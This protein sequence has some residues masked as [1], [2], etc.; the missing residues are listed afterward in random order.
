MRPEW[1]RAARRFAIAAI[2]AALAPAA[3]AGAQTPAAPLVYEREAVVCQSPHA[4]AAGARLLVAGGNA[5]DAAVAAAFALAVTYPEAG[6]IG[7]GGFLVLHVPGEGGAAPAWTT[8]DFRERAPARAHA[9]MFLD[10]QGRY[11][12]GRH[13]RSHL[14]VAVPGSVA[15]LALAHQRHGKRPWKEV[16]DPAIDLARRGFP[17]SRAL[18]GSLAREAPSF[19]PA[20]S[21]ARAFQKD[22][23]ALQAGEVWAQEELAA[24][25]ER[26]AREGPR[27]FYEGETARLV[28]REM[29]RG[30]GY[31]SAADLA[32]YQAIERPPLVG[33]YRGFTIVCMGPPSSGGVA[34]LECL[35]ILEGYDLAALGDLS[36]AFV[37]RAAEALRRAF[38]DRARHLGDPDFVEVPLAELVSKD[39]AARL[40]AGI[41]PARAS[42]SDPERFEWAP[43]G[44]Q[45]T[46]LSVVDAGG[47][48]VSLTT[49][50]EES[51]GARIVVPGAGFLLNNEMGDFNAGPALTNREGLIG[52]PANL[53]APGKRMLSSMSPAIICEGGEL[54]AVLGSPGGRTI[55]STVLGVVLRLIDF[56]RPVQEAVDAPRLHHQWL[57]DV[58]WLERGFSPDS[59]RI[60]EGFGHQLRWREGPQGSVMAITRDPARGILEVGVDRRRDGGASAGR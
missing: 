39:H 58:L 51:F 29:E 18:A 57:P 53:A 34:L 38:A 41:D 48:A 49:T 33:R 12:P 43:E 20:P 42:R 16:L 24:T 37:H 26:I 22:G 55:I 54:R 47:M 32:E 9:A 17:L 50:L 35:N 8:F 25:L 36:A 5:V 21:A 27:E 6:N 45:T 59:A 28:V 2:A 4:A 40:R 15:G 14:S 46:H 52:T 60:L 1:A 19:Q 23:R 3:R 30:G 56:R 11:D 31:V 10:A 13:H 7:G 44:E